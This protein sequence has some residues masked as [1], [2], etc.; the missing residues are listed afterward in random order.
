[1]NKDQPWTDTATWQTYTYSD[2]LAHW[3]G[4]PLIL[5]AG[6][7]GVNADGALKMNVND[8]F[9]TT[10]KDNGPG[11]GDSISAQG[12]EFPFDVWITRV[13]MTA[14]GG[15]GIVDGTLRVLSNQITVGLDTLFSF[16]WNAQVNRDTTIGLQINAGTRWQ[17]YQD[18]AG[19]SI[20]PDGPKVYIWVHPIENP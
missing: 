11:S 19:G 4:P 18:A 16:P 14:E 8:S 2:S 13:V 10:M 17:V 15:S 7:N 9:D 6:L 20:K 5:V 3:L 12:Y 1:V